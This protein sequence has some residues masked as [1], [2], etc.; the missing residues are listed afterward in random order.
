[1]HGE[2]RV[3]DGALS[4]T[5]A[6]STRRDEHVDGMRVLDAARELIEASKPSAPMDEVPHLHGAYGAAAFEFAGYLER[7]PHLPR[8]A[9][10]MPDLHLVVPETLV[11]FD[12]FTHEMTVSSFAGAQRLEGLCDTLASASAP[13]L[14]D[15]LGSCHAQLVPVAPYGDLVERAK[16]AIR[17]GDAFQIVLAQRWTAA[18]SVAPFNVYRALRAINPSP[19]MFF[20]DLGWGELFGSSPELLAVASAGRARIRPLAGTRARDADASRDARLAAQLRRDSKERAEHMMLVDLARND[21]AR[22]CAAGSVRVNEL[23]SIE[24]F[25]HV[26]HLVSDVSGLLRPG[27]DAFDLFAAA[28]PAGTVS[29]APKIRAMELIAEL[30]GRRRGF[31]AGSVCRF[32]F[33]G[34][35]DACITLRSAHAYDAALH[36]SAGAGLVADSQPEREDAE[37]RAKAQVLIAAIQR[38]SGAAMAVPQECAER[39]LVCA[40]T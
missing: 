9:D 34:S 14:A 17:A 28:F 35:L 11:I 24:R 36:L 23:L 25:S 31:Y 10:P 18:C 37:C 38:A 20:L 40:G 16:E 29:G 32:G 21:L 4:L 15:G 5:T 1:M 19:Y 2:L 26:M 8:G 12:H 3:A 6:R 30:E 39:G 27:R 7:L 22:V 33:D 13:H